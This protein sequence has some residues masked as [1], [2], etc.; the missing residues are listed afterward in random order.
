MK[1]LATTVH[2]LEDLAAQELRGKAATRGRVLFSRLRKS[3]M[4]VHRVMTLVDDFTFASFE[5]LLAQLQL[6]SLSFHGSFKIWCER[7][8]MHGFRSPDVGKAFGQALQQRGFTPDFK[9]PDNTVVVDIVDQ[10]CFVGLLIAENHC[11][12]D[13]RVRF[14]NQSVHACVAAALIRVAKLRKSDSI[15][16]PFCKDGVVAIEAYQAGITKVH[17]LD[18]L[19]NNARYATTNAAM[20]NV[21]LTFQNYD[22]TWI[23]TLFRERSLDYIVTNFFI[24]Q[25]DP[26]LH[27]LLTEFFTQADYVVRKGI[28]LVTNKPAVVKEHAKKFTLSAERLI[29]VGGMEYSLLVFRR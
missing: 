7:V 21:P 16:D 23:N 9:H 29:R 3:Y 17:A 19:K 26:H 27:R 13:Y 22:L 25:R 8:G 4:L 6:V 11:R 28:A 10:R 24:S 12:R 1:Y 20:G 14:N 5:D 2:G 15:L 18:P